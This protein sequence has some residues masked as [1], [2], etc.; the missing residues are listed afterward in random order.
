MHPGIVSEFSVSG[1][2]NS[3]NAKIV[4]HKILVK[5]LIGVAGNTKLMINIPDQARILKATVILFII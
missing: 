2:R 5:N 3:G 4:N 1:R